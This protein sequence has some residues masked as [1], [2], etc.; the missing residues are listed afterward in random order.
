MVVSEAR[1]SNSIFD[2]IST[3]GPTG[4][5]LHG[6]VLLWQLTIQTE[7]TRHSL[8]TT[9]RPLRQLMLWSPRYDSRSGMPVKRFPSIQIYKMFSFRSQ[10]LHDPN[11]HL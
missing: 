3:V 1:V 6:S 5:G 11:Y 10:T 2:T 7:E 9:S 8:E 4:M